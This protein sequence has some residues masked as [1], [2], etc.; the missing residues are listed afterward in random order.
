M[1]GQGTLP[2]QALQHADEV[3]T[4]HLALRSEALQ[5]YEDNGVLG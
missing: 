2:Q 1:S 3:L 4:C 5:A